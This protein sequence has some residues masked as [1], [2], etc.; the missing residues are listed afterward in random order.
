MTYTPANTRK[1]VPS[2]PGDALPRF[3]LEVI[4]AIEDDDAAVTSEQQPMSVA[5]A[6][7][8]VRKKVV[9]PTADSTAEIEADQILIETYLEDVE[10][11]A[12]PRPSTMLPPAM[13]AK[14]PASNPIPI[15]LADDDGEDL[16][17]AI[18]DID[19]FL[20]QT[21][22]KAPSPGG[23]RPVS[24]ASIEPPP[25]PPSRAPASIASFQVPGLKTPPAWQRLSWHPEDPQSRHEDLAPLS[26]APVAL[27]SM[28]VTPEAFAVSRPARSRVGLVV[29][30]ALLAC[31]LL[32]GASVPFLLPPGTVTKLT[33]SAS[34]L[35]GKSDE[36]KEDAKPQA[37]KAEQPKPPTPQPQTSAAVVA[38][39]VVAPAGMPSVSVDSLPRT[40]VE[41]KLTLVTLPPRAKGH[42][43][44]VDRFAFSGSVSPVKMACGKH[45]VKVGSR[46]APV[47]MD[48]P[49]GGELEVH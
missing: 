40:K 12:K 15:E 26:V 3:G 10:A 33:S 46:G 4:D 11:A 49:C 37:P 35:V 29:T 14:K 6:R 16:V 22:P 18:D 7:K 39:A 1:S 17:S 38:P 13:A 45:V 41:P 28:P 31:G 27:P 47:A 42:R 19:R 23:D 5:R 20:R 2:Q 43:V 24:L 8:V 21:S 48:F 9:A 34:S 36:K 25:R 32:A 44:W 30:C